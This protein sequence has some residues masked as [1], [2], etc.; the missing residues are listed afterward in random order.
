MEGKTL[1]NERKE[2]FNNVIQM[3][4][5]SRTPNVSNAYTWKILDSPYKLSEALNDYD[6][7]EKIIYD[8]HERYQFDAYMDLGSRNPIKVSNALNGG[9][10]IINDENESITVCD[11]AVM[12]REEYKEVAENPMKFNWER[13]FARYC[14]EDLTVE[15]LKNG[16]QEFLIFGQFLGKVNSKFKNEYQ[17]VPMG[18]N[19]VWHPF[20]YFFNTMRGIKEISIDLRKSKPEMIEAMETLYQTTIVPAV[21]QAIANDNSDYVTDTTTAFLGHSILSE[22]QFAELYWPILKRVIDK[23]SAN[24]KTMYIFCESTMMRFKDFFQDVPK[25]TLIIHLEQDN[26]FEMRKVLPNIC[27]AGGMTTDLLG[28][29]SKQQCI[30]YAKKLIDELGDG[31]IMSQNKMLS[32]RNDCKRENLIAVNEFVRNY[33]H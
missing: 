26:I 33:K 2:L 16:V 13:A 27:L 4:K 9:A 24:N 3:K 29:G 11:H 5:T 12:K 22:K 30:D 31:F 20:E 23:L 8:F 28:H 19:L 6:T 7:F 25:G 15:Q 1:F 21:E 18:S 10:Y 17:C 32:F 14:N